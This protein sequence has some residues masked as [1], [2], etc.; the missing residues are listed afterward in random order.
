M[1]DKVRI[2]KQEILSH[3]NKDEMAGLLVG[4]KERYEIDKDLINYLFAEMQSAK[5]GEK[6][7][8]QQLREAKRTIKELCALVEA[9][10]KGKG[11]D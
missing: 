6:E 5:L 2:T 11:S 1:A 7:L 3:F 10:K 9:L 8:I 4:S